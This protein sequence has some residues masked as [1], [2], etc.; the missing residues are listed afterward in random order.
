MCHRLLYEF[1]L[2]LFFHCEFTLALSPKSCEF[3]IH[4]ALWELPVV[5][6]ILTDGQTGSELLS[7]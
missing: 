4:G 1:L 7:L 3:V 6:F 2:D 5:G